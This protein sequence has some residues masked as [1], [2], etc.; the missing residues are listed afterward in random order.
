MF[1]YIPVL[2]GKVSYFAVSKR[3]SDWIS[4]L[5]QEKSGWIVAT[6]MAGGLCVLG[7]FRDFY[8]GVGWG[9]VGGDVNVLTTTSLMLHVW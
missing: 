1:V 9:G 8:N 6:A 4:L 3:S 7:D 2:S 5:G